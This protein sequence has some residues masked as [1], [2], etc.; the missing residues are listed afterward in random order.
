MEHI[1]SL[2]VT[3]L[4]MILAQLIAV[5][6]QYSNLARL[7]EA[8]HNRVIVNLQNLLVFELEN[9]KTIVDEKTQMLNQT[10]EGERYNCYFHPI[11]L[12]VLFPVYIG[13]FNKYPAIDPFTR[14]IMDVYAK[15]I[16][17]YTG[18]LINNWYIDTIML[19]VREPR[20]RSGLRTDGLQQN[21]VRH[22]VRL[23]QWKLE[24]ENSLRLLCGRVDRVR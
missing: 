7:S 15:A 24:F 22:C 16:V 20:Q 18:F 8:E 6:R 14:D 2:I 10:P 19:E 9:F 12:E 21:A 3:G 17:C 5:R 23:R 13:A 1:L 11:A 4:L